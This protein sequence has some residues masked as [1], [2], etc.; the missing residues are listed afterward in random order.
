MGALLPLQLFADRVPRFYVQKPPASP[1]VQFFLDEST[2]V[3]LAHEGLELFPC[4][5]FLRLSDLDSVAGV[6]EQGGGEGI[7]Y[8][9]VKSFVVYFV[10]DLTLDLIDRLGF[11]GNVSRVVILLGPISPT[12]GQAPSVRLPVVRGWNLSQLFLLRWL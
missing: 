9:A 10:G 3:T 7:R 8:S 5:L 6:E 4:C 11:I 1:L 12:I 2:I